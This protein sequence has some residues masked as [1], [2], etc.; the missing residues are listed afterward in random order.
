MAHRIALGVALLTFLVSLGCDE[1]KSK[2]YRSGYV[3]GYGV[4]TWYVK[5]NGKANSKTYWDKKEAEEGKEKWIAGYVK[6]NPDG[7]P[8]PKALRE[9]ADGIWDGMKDGFLD[10][11]SRVAKGESK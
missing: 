10:R 1:P 2:D 4:G 6:N 3:F 8:D 9:H 5:D 7:I 11:P